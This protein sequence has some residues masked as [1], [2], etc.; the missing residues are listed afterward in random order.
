VG[1]THGTVRQYV[2]QAAQRRH[3]DE[4]ITPP[5]VEFVLQRAHNFNANERSLQDRN[6]DFT[7]TQGYAV[8]LS[9]AAPSTAALGLG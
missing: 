8:F 7:V 1:E 9:N 5:F 3:F 6:R 4:V 2:G